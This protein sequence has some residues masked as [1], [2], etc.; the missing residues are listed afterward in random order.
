MPPSPKGKASQSAGNEKA[1]LHA[2][3]ARTHFRPGF[4]DRTVQC[5]RPFFHTEKRP[6]TCVVHRGAHKARYHPDSAAKPQPS[7]KAI[8]GAIRRGLLFV[9][10]RSSGRSDRRLHAPA[11]TNRRFS[12]PYWARC[13]PSSLFSIVIHCIGRAPK[14][15]GVFH[16]LAQPLLCTF[17]A[18]PSA[19]C[20]SPLHSGLPQMAHSACG[21]SVIQ[22]CTQHSLVASLALPCL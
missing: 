21:S 8:D 2:G 20:S 12:L 15:Q 18:Q 16:I 10:L 22:Q 3:S 14:C 11:Y 13:V 1:P 9:H 17:L 7:V 5:P 6:C 19:E 4:P